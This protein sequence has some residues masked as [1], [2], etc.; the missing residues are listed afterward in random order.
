MDK[1]TI[2]R[3]FLADPRYDP[4]DDHR[5]QKDKGP[6]NRY[7]KMCLDLGYNEEVDALPRSR[8][9]SPK[10]ST[11]I[12]K[13]ISPTESA[14]SASPVRPIKVKLGPGKGLTGFPDIDINIILNTD[15]NDL[16]NLLK[17]DKTTRN[18]IVELLPEI[19]PKNRELVNFIYEL[20][21]NNEVAIAKK[22]LEIAGKHYSVSEIYTTLEY[23]I[24]QFDKD[25]HKIKSS[26]KVPNQ[27]LL[28]NYFSIAPSNYG[29]DTFGYI[30]NH[31]VRKNSTK[32]LYMLSPDK[33]LQLLKNIDFAAITVKKRIIVNYVDVKLRDFSV[34]RSETKK[35]RDEI[36]KV[37]SQNKQFFHDNPNI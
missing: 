26:F 12:P 22:T 29:W 13:K 20:L 9:Q 23:E 2:C 4:I 21:K 27:Q 34:F 28:E 6:Y 18:L 30:I 7:V 1:D 32:P 35:E 25:Y 15:I 37:L 24:L 36:D 3:K 19:I 14:R 33:H 31:I 16:I 10:K 17:T 5:L 11:K 8:T